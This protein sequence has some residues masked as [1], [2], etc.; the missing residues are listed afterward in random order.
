[1]AAAIE[2]IHISKS[3]VPMLA[4]VHVSRLEATPSM[5]LKPPRAVVASPATEWETM[6]GADH[7]ERKFEGVG[8]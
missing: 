4:L 6:V 8:K 5:P 2:K 1:M 3:V 7:L